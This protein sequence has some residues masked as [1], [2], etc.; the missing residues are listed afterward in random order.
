MK[1][2]MLVLMMLILPLMSY[3]SISEKE[4]CGIIMTRID[5]TRTICDATSAYTKSAESKYQDVS[6]GGQDIA[7]FIIVLDRK[8]CNSVVYLDKE[9]SYN[10]VPVK[11]DTIGYRLQ[12]VRVK[13]GNGDTFK[14]KDEK[15]IYILKRG[16]KPKG[17]N[18]TIG[19]LS[20]IYAD[21]CFNEE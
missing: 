17:D 3:A 13:T 1:K 7:Q 9:G 5:N 8:K 15:I 21:R 2:F 20:D 6:T 11:V 14:I 19:A 18:N 16:D 12:L 10:K 4:A